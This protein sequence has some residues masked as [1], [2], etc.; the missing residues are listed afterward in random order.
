MNVLALYRR[1]SRWPAGRWLFAR[2]VCLRAPYFASIAPRVDALE[3]GRCVVSLRHR[4]AVSN[5][6]G[7]VHAIALCNAA[8]L[9]A[10]LATDAALPASLR[11][12]PKG[13]QVEYVRK[14]QGR[15]T[16]T[17]TLRDAVD[18]SGARAMP[19]DVEITDPDGAVVCRA[20]VSMWVS[21]RT[22]SDG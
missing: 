17:A 5:H 13:M 1:M 12:I 16:A 15:M 22:R 20:V 18:A 6:I 2:A 7:T 10:G 21:P 9:A 3:P 11:W 14:A 19:V 4:R 8:E